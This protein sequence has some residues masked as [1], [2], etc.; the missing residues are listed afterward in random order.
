MPR[1]LNGIIGL[2]GRI[3]E[4]FFGVDSSLVTVKVVVLIELRL[5]LLSLSGNFL[6]AGT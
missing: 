1:G 6:F 3:P 5:S 4:P 2:R